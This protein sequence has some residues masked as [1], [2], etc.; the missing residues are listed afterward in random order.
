MAETHVAGQLK[1]QVVTPE[2]LVVDKAADFVIITAHD[3]QIG[4]MPEHSAYLG[5]LAPGIM[6]IDTD[7]KQ[8]YYFVDGGF[9]E[10]LDNQVTILTPQAIPANK[11]DPQAITDELAQAE[12]M[13]TQPREDLEKRNNAL[14]KARAKRAVLAAI[15]NIH[16]K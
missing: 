7:K 16:A 1:C 2:K 15:Q 3:G 9:A 11:L 8:E 13:P 5:R 12:D 10:I 14:A 4:I 6:R